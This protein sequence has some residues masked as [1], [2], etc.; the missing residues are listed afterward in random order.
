M[1]EINILFKNIEPYSTGY[2]EVDGHEIYYEECGNPSGKPVVFLHP[3]SCNGTL[4]ELEE[5]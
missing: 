3:K 2:L 4:I 1:S 5:V